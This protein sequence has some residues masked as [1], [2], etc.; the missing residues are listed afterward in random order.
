MQQRPFSRI[1]ILAVA[2]PTASGK[3][4]LA[5]ELA[6]CLGG[7]VIAADSMQ[8]YADLSIGTARPTPEEMGEIPHHL[9]GFLPLSHTYSVAQYV[10]DAHRIVQEV[11]ARGS[12][13]ILCGGTGLY[14]R[15]LLENLTFTEQKTDPVLRETLRRRA[16]VEGGEALLAELRAFD[17]ETAARLHAN[18]T[19]R[20]VRAIEAYRMTGIP[21]SEQ[22]RRSR[23]QPSPYEA[24]LLVL[25][26]HER[27]LLY[28]R[29][30]QRVDDML[31]AGLEEEARRALASPY[32]ATAM[33]AIGYKELAPY[34]E[35]VVSREEALDKLKRSTR[36]YA[37]RQISW[38]HHME[39]AHL[40]YID[41]YP[42]TQA[43]CHAALEVWNT[44]RAG[45]EQR[46]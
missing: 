22:A 8:I 15:A 23:E 11:A 25:D 37:K 26:V 20:I 1:P 17:P 40:L 41:E 6:R 24:C 9:F 28:D 32:G 3:S 10:Q 5:V 18:D 31:A 42:D 45:K 16:Q 35:G 43:L 38:F 19:G 13:P 4:A 21:L 14:L 30:N 33:Q 39:G 46:A 2:G 29:I 7:E 12:L 44:Y 36:R 27:R 34:F